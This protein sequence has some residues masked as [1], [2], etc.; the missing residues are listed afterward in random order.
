MKRL[1]FA[2]LLTIL[3]AQTACA[4]PPGTPVPK[5]TDYVELNK[6]T[7]IFRRYS[8]ILGNDPDVTAVLLTANNNPRH[9]IV[10]VKDHAAHDRLLKQYGGTIEGLDVWYYIDHEPNP[11]DPIEAVPKVEEPKTWWEKLIA[12]FAAWRTRISTTASPEPSPAP[13]A[14]G[15]KQI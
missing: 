15:L 8:H 13:P 9:M 10:H 2:L 3:V 6:S 14:A 12:A 11:G 5:P 1:K 7:D 4:T